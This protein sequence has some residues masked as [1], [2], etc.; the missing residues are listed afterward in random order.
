MVRFS[1]V[2]H[3]GNGTQKKKTLVEL[4]VHTAGKGPDEAAAA[5][6]AHVASCHTRI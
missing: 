1:G 6:L 3:Y 2:E 5:E 4:V